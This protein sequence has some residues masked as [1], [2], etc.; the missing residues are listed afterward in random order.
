M[1]RKVQA[2]VRCNRGREKRGTFMYIS[3]ADGTCMLGVTGSAG[4]SKGDSQ[5]FGLSNRVN[6]W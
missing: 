6:G 3:E 4:G 5:A 2:G 1:V